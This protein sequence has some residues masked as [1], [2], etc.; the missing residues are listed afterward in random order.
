MPASTRSR[1][2]AILALRISHVDEHSLVNVTW[3][4]GFLL[5]RC[6]SSSFAPCCWQR[7]SHAAASARKTA[8]ARTQN[9]QMAASTAA[10]RAAEVRCW[11][12]RVSSSLESSSFSSLSL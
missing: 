6:W 8:L 9:R 1:P 10:D 4:S 11:T 7:Q 12:R 3:N 2:S 5:V